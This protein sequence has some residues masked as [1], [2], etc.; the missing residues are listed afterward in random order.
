LTSEKIKCAFLNAASDLYEKAI[1][2]SSKEILV[3]DSIS[4]MVAQI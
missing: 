4:K 2:V 1:E 3:C